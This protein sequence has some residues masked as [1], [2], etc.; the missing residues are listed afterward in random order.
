MSENI[1]TTCKHEG[2]TKDPFCNPGRM[3]V[4]SSYEIHATKSEVAQLRAEVERLKGRELE[5]EEVCRL[6]RTDCEIAQSDLAAAVSELERVRG[7]RDEL[8]EKVAKALESSDLSMDGC[9][10]T[11]SYCED[12]GE[13]CREC[14]NQYLG[15]K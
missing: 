15:I 10:T 3:L 1:C 12:S 11:K 14:W 4:C 5:S 7:E 13:D 9:P 6:F 8:K 2:T